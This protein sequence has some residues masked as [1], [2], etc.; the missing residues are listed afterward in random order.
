MVENYTMHI[1]EAMPEDNDE[2]QELQAKCPMGTTLIVSTVNTPD[3]FARARAYESHKVFVACEDNRIIGSAACAIRDPVVNGNIHRVGYEFQYF[4]SPDYR[5]KG[6]ARR[7]HQHIEDYLT[8][9]GV[10]LSYCLIMEGNLSSMRLFESQGFKLH[11][12]L[13]MLGLGIYK[14]MD[15]SSKGNIRSVTSEDLATVA[16]LLNE[17][18][19]GYDL[20]EPTSAEALTQFVNRTPTYS[21]NNLVILEDRGEILACLG[22]WDWSQITQI[23]VKARSLKIRMIGLLLNISRYLQ[24]MPRSL[25]PGDTLKQM[26]LTPIAFKDPRYLAVLLRYMNNQALLRGIEQIFCVCERDHVLL[27]SMR[28][29]IRVDTATYLYIKLLQQNVSMGEKPVFIDGIDL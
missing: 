18:W 29:F 22:F 28:G 25:K 3:F 24:P 7:L 17:T 16:E 11:R 19:Q 27:K 6:V 4:T 9:Q 1:H 10:L 21:F 8:R 15:V 5:R 12:T 2:L 23:T 14:E 13:V 20:Y 26:V